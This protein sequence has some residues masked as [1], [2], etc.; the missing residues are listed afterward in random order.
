[1]APRKL[2]SPVTAANPAS[3]AD[4]FTRGKKPTTTDR[5]IA[6]KK[7]T[8]TTLFKHT[9]APSNNKVKTQKQQEGQNQNK[10][11]DT[12]SRTVIVI[13]DSE[14]DDK[15]DDISRDEAGG[16]GDDAAWGFGDDLGP[17]DDFFSDDAFESQQRQS[18]LLPHIKPKKDVAEFLITPVMPRASSAKRTHSHL[19]STPSVNIQLGI[20]QEDIS[21]QEK[22]LRQFD[23]ASK[24]GPCLD[25]TR[26]ERWERASLLG[27]SPPM[28]VKDLL[29]KDMTINTS[30]FSGRV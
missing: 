27:L 26:L 6:V 7:T 20:H 2:A 28:D 11:Q 25:M 10:L 4:F 18:K 5:V 8:T 3:A 12:T 19:Q 14:D 24:Y 17:L 13:S 29:A 15:A 22:T 23:L 16:N 1:M 30:I 21:E 9:P